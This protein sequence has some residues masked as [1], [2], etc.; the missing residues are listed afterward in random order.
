MKANELQFH[1]SMWVNFKCML[2]EKKEEER[3]E[4][5]ILDRDIQDD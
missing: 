2:R 3:K 1:N 4:K 5:L